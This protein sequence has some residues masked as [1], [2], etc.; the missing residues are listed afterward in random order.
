LEESAFESWCFEKIKERRRAE[1]L[2]LVIRMDKIKNLGRI[3][4]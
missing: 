3:L 4:V 2:P 1:K